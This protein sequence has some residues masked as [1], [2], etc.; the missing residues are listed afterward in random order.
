MWWPTSSNDNTGNGE[1]DNG[2][3]EE[4]AP[5]VFGLDEEE[6]GSESVSL[7]SEDSDCGI[8]AAAAALQNEANDSSFSSP[9]DSS[10]S[11]GC[12]SSSSSSSSE[13]RERIDHSKKRAS[14]PPAQEKEEQEVQEDGELDSVAARNAKKFMRR[15]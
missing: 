11:S 15:S 8:A 12:S 13:Q 14:P 6:G 7:G 2:E 1:R 10:D 3:D 9:S 5:D 4:E